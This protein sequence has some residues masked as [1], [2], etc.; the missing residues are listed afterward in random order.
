MRSYDNDFLIDGKPI[1]VPDEGVEIGLEDL[2]SDESGRDES[3]VMHRIVL[4]YGVM[5]WKLSYSSLTLEEWKYM[6]GLFA[7]KAEFTVKTLDLD[8][9]EKTYTAYCSKMSLALHNKK[10]GRFKG[11]SF[12][13]IEC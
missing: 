11:L 3:G 4:R 6:R 13:I 8:G 10:T 2:D 9:T 12:S 1:L 5:T 7:G